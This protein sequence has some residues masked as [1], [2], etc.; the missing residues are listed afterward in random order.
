ML[1]TF[2]PKKKHVVYL[3]DGLQLRHLPHNLPPS[4]PAAVLDMPEEIQECLLA[5]FKRVLLRVGCTEIY[6]CYYWNHSHRF[7]LGGKNGSKQERDRTKTHLDLFCRDEP[8]AAGLFQI[9][10]LLHRECEC[11]H[12]GNGVGKQHSVDEVGASNRNFVLHV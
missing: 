6:F 9:H 11:G 3:G 1:R 5:A 10:E 7:F 8:G 12:E 2:F 4:L